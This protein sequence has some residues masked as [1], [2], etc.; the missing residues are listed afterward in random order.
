LLQ[1]GLEKIFS[2]EADFSGITEDDN[3][4]HIDEI[5]QKVFMEVDEKGAEVAN[6]AV[7]EYNFI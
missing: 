5:V 6:G 2:G 4:F 1:L 3:T 7:G